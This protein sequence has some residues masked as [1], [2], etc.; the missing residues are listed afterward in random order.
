MGRNNYKA[1]VQELKRIANKD[2]RRV[3]FNYSS[4]TWRGMNP[5]AAK[6]LKRKGELNER[7]PKDTIL[8]NRYSEHNNKLKSQTLRHE[9]IED[10]IMRRKG[11]SYKKA[12]NIAC[13][14]QSNRNILGE[15]YDKQT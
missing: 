5:S 11:Y 6:E 12:H 9:I 7:P 14:Q 13:R 1:E 15:K 3:S 2:G 10:R 8:I 4:E